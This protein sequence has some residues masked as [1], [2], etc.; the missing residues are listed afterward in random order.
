MINRHRIVQI[1]LHWCMLLAPPHFV[2]SPPDYIQGIVHHSNTVVFDFKK[3]GHIFYEWFPSLFIHGCH[4]QLSVAAG[5]TCCTSIDRGLS[6]PPIHAA[7]CSEWK[8]KS[9]DHTFYGFF[10]ATFPYTNIHS[11]E[12]DVPVPR[13]PGIGNFYFSCGIGTGVGKI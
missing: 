1:N 5:L 11:T 10:S 4:C 6:K 2:L 9:N 13:I 8:T 7:T 3:W 12:C